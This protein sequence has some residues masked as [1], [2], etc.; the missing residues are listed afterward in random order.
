MLCN[1]N[2]FCDAN[3]DNLQQT[4]YVQVWAIDNCFS[5]EHSIVAAYIYSLIW[6]RY[7]VD[8]SKSAGKPKNEFN[9]SYL[10]IWSRGHLFS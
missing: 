6:K 3:I 2:P 1:L 4:G 10:C 8:D 9:L 7:K 5:I